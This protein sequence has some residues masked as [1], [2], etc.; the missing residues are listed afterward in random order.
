MMRLRGRR[1]LSEGGGRQRVFVVRWT[2]S[3]SQFGLA[4]E[5][6]G[7]GRRFDFSSASRLQGE[8]DM[9]LLLLLLCFGT[10]RVGESEFLLA[11]NQPAGFIAVRKSVKPR[12]L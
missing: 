10:L 5:Q 6:I 4:E 11:V 8:D 9:K 7:L 2:K 1:R 12:S 3:V